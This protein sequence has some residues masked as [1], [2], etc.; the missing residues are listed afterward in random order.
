MVELAPHGTTFMLHRFRIRDHVVVLGPLGM[1]AALLVVLGIAL[2]LWSGTLLARMVVGAGVLGVAWLVRLAA[3]A[4]GPLAVEVRPHGVLAGGRWI[5]RQELVG[6]H[7]TTTGALRL[8]IEVDAPG[9]DDWCSPR[10]DE[11]VERLE[12]IADAIRTLV[13]SAEERERHREAG[14]PEALARLRE[15]P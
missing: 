10:L 12:S 15:T 11:T 1:A 7:L 9:S 13:P 6:A 8:V 5:P 4:L 14:V 2:V 3:R